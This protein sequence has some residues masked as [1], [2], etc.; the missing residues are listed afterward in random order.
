MTD[1]E[2]D[3]ENPRPNGITPGS[4]ATSGTR[5]RTSWPRRF[6]SGRLAMAKK[7]RTGC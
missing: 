4:Q 5:S 2:V 3:P 7:G 1:D 6:R